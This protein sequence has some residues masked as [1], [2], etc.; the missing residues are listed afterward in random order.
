MSVRTKEPAAK[1]PWPPKAANDPLYRYPKP[2]PVGRVQGESLATIAKKSKIS[3]KDLLKYNFLT[4]VPEEINW[5]LANYVRCPEPRPSQQYYELFGA[6][7]D[8]KSN[9][10][11]IFIPTHGKETT[12]P[13]NRLGERIVEDYNNTANKEP[14]GLCYE[15]CYARVKKAGSPSGVTVPAWK[16]NSTFGLIWGSLVAQPGWKSVPEEYKGLG[17]AGAM[18][19]AGLGTL[20]DMEGIWR[21]DLEP[22]AVIQVWGSTGDYENVRKGNSAYGHSFIFLNYVYAGS[23]ISA[24]AIADQGYQNSTPLVRGDWGVWFGANLFRKPGREPGHVTYGPNP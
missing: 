24:M 18:V 20:V 8:E 16:N 14:G 23:V 10:G 19:W 21:G 7:Y 2:Y 9:T 11:V 13:L 5:Y 6:K 4:K 3:V 22:G 15:T 12:I 17:A 1:A